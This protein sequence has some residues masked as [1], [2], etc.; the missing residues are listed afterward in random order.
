MLLYRDKMS[1]FEQRDEDLVFWEPK[2]VSV[3]CTG[4]NK[5]EKRL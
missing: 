1:D 2:V 4:S 3:G 5:N